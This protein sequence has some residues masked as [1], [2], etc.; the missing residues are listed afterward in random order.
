MSSSVARFE[1]KLAAGLVLVGRFTDRREALDYVKANP[2][3]MVSEECLALCLAEQKESWR[4]DP[5]LSDLSDGKK[6]GR[7][8]TLLRDSM[9]NQN[10]KPAETRRRIELPECIEHGCSNR[11]GWRSNWHTMDWELA[12]EQDPYHHR[13]DECY[14]RRL[15][16]EEANREAHFRLDLQ[17][18]VTGGYWR[19][20]RARV[21]H[22]CCL[23]S[24]EI[25][26]TSNYSMV[27][28]RGPR[29]HKVC[30]EC[31]DVLDNG[32]RLVLRSGRL[33]TTIDEASAS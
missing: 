24:G 17:E 8:A 1:R 11:V 5:M 3:R 26:P 13:C 33:S 6:L 7:L 15:A 27:T 32:H 21:S 20:V 18:S 25:E 23:C 12:V 28:V 19:S 30:L 14:R 10:H 22:Q 4:A 29:S 2:K 31:F 9:R 16:E